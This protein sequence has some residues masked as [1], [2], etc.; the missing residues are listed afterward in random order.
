LA[1]ELGNPAFAIPP[2]RSYDIETKTVTPNIHRL[3]TL[4]HIYGFDLRELLGWYG[5]P[6]R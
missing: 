6:R 3:Y 5:V 1:R 2:S 4:A